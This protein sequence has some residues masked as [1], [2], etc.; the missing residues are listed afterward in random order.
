MAKV[1]AR[2]HTT[3][4]SALERARFTPARR[5]RA[6]L[7]DAAQYDTS[8]LLQDWRWLVPEPATALLISAFGDRV[9]GHPDGSL[10][11]L[12]PTTAE[13]GRSACDAGQ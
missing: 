10:W 12:S 9:F 2:G 3:A 5:L 6:L 8:R 7:I 13:N 4:A 11:A 1:S